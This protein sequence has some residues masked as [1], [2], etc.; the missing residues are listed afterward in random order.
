MH[1]DAKVAGQLKTNKRNWL[2][3]RGTDDWPWEQWGQEPQMPTVLSTQ[4]VHPRDRLSYWRETASAKEVDFSADPGFHATLCNHYLDNVAVA[5]LDCE[6]CVIGR[7]ARNIARTGSDHFVLCMQLSGREL[8]L[9]ATVWPSTK[10]AD[11]FSSIRA[12][13]TN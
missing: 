11:L 7:S 2:G 10:T 3:R 13:P 6:P 8:P 1:H 9:R 5:E 12:G 4:D